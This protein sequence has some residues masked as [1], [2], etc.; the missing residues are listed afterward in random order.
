MKTCWSFGGTSSMGLLG[1][2]SLQEDYLTGAVNPQR[3]N[4]TGANL[5]DAN[6]DDVISAE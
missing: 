5:Q 3:A 2:A 4:L 6:L 1:G